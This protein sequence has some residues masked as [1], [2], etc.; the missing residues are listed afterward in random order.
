MVTALVRLRHALVAGNQCLGTW[1]DLQLWLVVTLLTK[2]NMCSTNI[3]QSG[4]Q[5]KGFRWLWMTRGS[6][7]IVLVHFLAI[8]F[9]CGQLVVQSQ[10]CKSMVSWLIPSHPLVLSCNLP[11]RMRPSSSTRFSWGWVSMSSPSYRKWTKGGSLQF[12]ALVV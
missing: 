11:W 6:H 3:L 12:K 1:I 10:S 2:W 9:G 7:M 5:S 8:L 4:I